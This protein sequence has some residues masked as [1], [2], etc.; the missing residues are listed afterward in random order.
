MSLLRWQFE[1]LCKKK[2]IFLIK[3][4]NF[5]FIETNGI[6]N[7]LIW[8]TFKNETTAIQPSYEIKDGFTCVYMIRLINGGLPR[9]S[10]HDYKYVQELAP[11]EVNFKS[12]EHE[13]SS[14]KNCWETVL[15][16]SANIL[17]KHGVFVLR[18]DFSIFDKINSQRNQ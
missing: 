8:T 10:A 18:G 14:L 12:Y 5:K 9:F 4:Y 3:E 15:T 11:E 6:R 2:L 16:E 13:Y 17:R 1:K 7:V